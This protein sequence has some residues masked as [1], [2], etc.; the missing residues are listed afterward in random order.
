MRH[1]DVA[2][3]VTCIR[4][5]G[6][7]HFLLLRHRK[8]GDWSLVGG[9]VETGGESWASAAMRETQEELP[10]LKGRKD[11]VLLPI[12]STPVTWG[13]EFSRSAGNR[14]TMYEAQFF[15]MQLLDEPNAIFSRLPVEDLRLVSQFDLEHM[16]DL[17]KPIRVLAQR[18]RGGLTSIPLAWKESVPRDVLPPQL[19]EQVSAEL[20]R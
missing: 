3:I 5:D 10:P 15:A 7:P 18:L 11:F 2:Y 1:S 20:T 14:E 13:P 6:V 16:P 9:H 17:A 4:V 12:F 8:W 19:F